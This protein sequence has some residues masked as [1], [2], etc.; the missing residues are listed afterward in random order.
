MKF[1]F[2][3][4]KQ[5]LDEKMCHFFKQNVSFLSIVSFFIEECVIFVDCVIIS[6]ECVIVSRNI[7]LCHYDTKCVSLKAL[8]ERP[9]LSKFPRL[10]CVYKDKS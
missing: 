7:K 1:Y 9:E 2:T 6:T 3:F 10:T 4:K 8:E 5:D